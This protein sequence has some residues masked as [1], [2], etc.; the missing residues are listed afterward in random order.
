MRGRGRT[1]KRG[2]SPGGGAPG[3]SVE[4]L[5]AEASK[6]GPKPAYLFS[7][8]EF[9]ISKAVDALVDV[10]VP[11]SNR[12]LNLSLLDGATA[13][14][15]VIARDLAQ[16][17]ML[18]GSK[19]VV[20]R[21]TTLLTAK[22]DLGVEVRRAMQSYKDGRERDAARRLMTVVAK[23]KWSVPDLTEA[24]ASRWEK[25]LGVAAEDV[26]P[27]FLAAMRS[28]IEKEEIKTPG[29][30]T[31]A[32]ERLL[33]G[34]AP[35][36]NVLVLTCA[37]PDR[38]LA[39]TKLIEGLGVHLPCKTERTGRNVEDVDVSAIRDDVLA[40]YGKR[41]HPEAERAL[42]RRIGDEMRL[43]AGEMEKL[44]LFVGDRELITPD[45]V[46]SVG[47][48]Q[49]RE[50]AFWEL[51]SAV[52]E[53]N[54]EGA[55]WFLHDAFEHN[56]HPV[57]ALA[58]IGGALRKALEV[59]SVAERHG[60]RTARRDLPARVVE[61]VAELRG[62]RKPHPFALRKEYERSLAW[63]STRGL[64]EALARCRDADRDLKTGRGN[65]KL[66]V[67]RLLVRLCA[68]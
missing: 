31:A 18:R 14:P 23:A 21:D 42:K 16:A 4:S 49:V 8:D 47:V 45:D 13:D 24:P 20:V 2:S 5:V 10:L 22:A 61:E 46:N 6:N 44:C 40:R 54:L 50:E 17:P 27:E 30:D 34:G 43:F 29:T 32:L 48:R 41:L 68:H 63:T 11:A 3:P 25:D 66:I 65:G 51:G 28:L 19:L 55:L 35:P 58:G 59:R 7:G 60:V 53:R 26:N 37:K 64:A 36:G 52:C 15:G 67:E 56:R 12:A 33:E 39:L 57:Q 1:S 9:L 62:G 38:R